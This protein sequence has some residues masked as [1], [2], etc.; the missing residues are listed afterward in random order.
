MEMEISKFKTARFTGTHNLNVIKASAMH[1]LLELWLR[2]VR[3]AV[4]ALLNMRH[5]MPSYI[6]K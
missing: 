6:G 5:I 2:V 4:G 3:P 1:I